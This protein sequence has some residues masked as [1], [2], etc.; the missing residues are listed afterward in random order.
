MCFPVIV[1]IYCITSDIFVN[2]KTV[3]QYPFA[4]CLCTC[5]CEFVKNKSSVVSGLS[6]PKKV[7]LQY[8]YMYISGVEL[9]NIVLFLFN[10]DFGTCTLRRC[11]FNY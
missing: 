10:F 7:L 5:F 3:V 11:T 1:S 8:V 2:I 6:S 4:I 9:I